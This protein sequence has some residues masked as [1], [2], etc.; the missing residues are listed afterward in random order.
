MA[1]IKDVANLAGVSVATVSRVVNN[2]GYVSEKT[3]KNV[4]QA[5]AQLDYRPNEVARSLYQKKSRIV[6]LI[7]PDISNPFF[8]QMARGVEEA[9][10]E[11]G[12][13]IMLGNAD[14]DEEKT[15]NCL[16]DFKQNNV[17]GVIVAS[18][19]DNAISV[20]MPMVLLDRIP[21]QNI[22][23][24]VYSDGRTG[25]RIA[26]EEVLKRGARNIVLQHGPL[27]LQSA[28]DRFVSA[29]EVLEKAAVHFGIMPVPSFSYESAAQSAINTLKK[30]PE[31]DTII[32]V[33]DLHAI[34]LIQEAQRI[35]M[36]IPED[37]QVIGFDDIP[38]S[39][40]IYPSL[41]TIHQP[42]YNLG[43]QAAE[44]LIRVMNGE[45]IEKRHMILPVELVVRD[46]LRRRD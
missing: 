27:R 32:A 5:I 35:G 1:T 12:Y 13:R 10:E 39:S 4:E 45:M 2:T 41:S 8:P 16:Q 40:L 28:L 36:K 31:A 38:M 24:S 11:A 43:K 15:R 22:E 33:N 42:A 25:G 37:L 30:F 3:R 23:Y 20:D 9:L 17:A 14:E 18:A 26:A 6:G 29:L 21:F 34:T 44:L 7:L 19:T 46:S